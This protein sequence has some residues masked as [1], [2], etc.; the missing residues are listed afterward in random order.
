MHWTGMTITIRVSQCKNK[1]WPDCVKG[2][3]S[4]RTISADTSTRSWNIKTT[5]ITVSFSVLM[6]IIN[7]PLPM[8]GIICLFH[9]IATAHCNSCQ[10]QFSSQIANV[11]RDLISPHHSWSYYLPPSRKEFRSIALLDI[12]LLLSEER[13]LKCH[14]SVPWYLYYRQLVCQEPQQSNDSWTT[15][16]WGF[17]SYGS[18]DIYL[19]SRS[20]VD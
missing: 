15:V 17:W 2:L 10:A 11:V 14:I 1:K 18:L 13:L 16:A 8:K 3:H 9:I 5:S 20:F 4:A 12:M 19:K 7:G 6:M